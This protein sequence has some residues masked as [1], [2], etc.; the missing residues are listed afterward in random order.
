MQ[1][2]TANANAPRMEEQGN[3]QAQGDNGRLYFNWDWAKYKSEY[4]DKVTEK[5]KPYRNNR[6]PGDN[7]T[8]VGLLKNEE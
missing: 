7:C 5:I 6:Q 1:T 8:L 2:E 3:T 4:V